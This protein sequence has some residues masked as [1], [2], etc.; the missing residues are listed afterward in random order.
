MENT[1]LIAVSSQSVLR[2]QMDVI[3]N[4]LANMNTSGFKGEKMLFREH[5]VRSRGGEQVLG[6][7][8]HF[9]TDVATVRDMSEGPLVKTGNP[10]DVAIRGKGMLAIR[11][12]EGERYTRNGSLLIDADGNLTTQA[13]H[14]VLDD[15]GQPV[16]LGPGDTNIQVSRDGTISSDIGR[17]GKLKIVE[18]EN[19]NDMQLIAGGVYFSDAQPKDAESPDVVQ[20]MVEGSNVEPIIELTRMIEVSRAYQGVKTMIEK[21]DERIKKMVQEYGRTA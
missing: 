11:T 6:D 10:L 15:A 17:L 4:N 14:R 16:Q 13:G 5:L 9:V 2:R 18:F 8:L 3:A 21:E 1:S 20:G 7:T 19:P 12:E